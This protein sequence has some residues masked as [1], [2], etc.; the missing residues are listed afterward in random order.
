MTRVVSVLYQRSREETG[1]GKWLGVRVFRE[2]R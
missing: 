2:E 1:G